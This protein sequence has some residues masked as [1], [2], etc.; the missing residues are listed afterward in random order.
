MTMNNN[1]LP[2]RPTCSEPHFSCPTCRDEGLPARVLSVDEATN[3]ATAQT[4]GGEQEI[5]L[6]LLDGV[7]VGDFVLVHL[8]TAIA[9]LDAADVVE[10]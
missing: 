3:T 2:L 5:A 10:A 8:A 9:K 4:E 1:T 6:D 7:Q